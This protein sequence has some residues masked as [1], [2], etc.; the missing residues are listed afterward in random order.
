MANEW[1]GNKWTANGERLQITLAVGQRCVKGRIPRS[2][3]N[4]EHFYFL[5]KDLLG[6]QTN[7][8]RNNIY[9]H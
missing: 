7:R 4:E 8:R 9:V 6:Q 5:Q 1:N 2:T 3:K